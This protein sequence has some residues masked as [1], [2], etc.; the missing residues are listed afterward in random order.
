MKRSKLIKVM[1]ITAGQFLL[2]TISVSFAAWV[3]NVREERNE[4]QLAKVLLSQMLNELRGDEEQLAGEIPNLEKRISAAI[5]ML[6]ILTTS[7][8][9]DSMKQLIA[10]LNYWSNF[11]YNKATYE[12]LKSIGLNVIENDSLRQEIVMHYEYRANS[13]ISLAH[14]SYDQLFQNYVPVL[15]EHFKDFT[16]AGGATP[17]NLEP[18]RQ[19]NDVIVF[20]GIW[21]DLMKYQL[22]VQMYT[23]DDTN[24]L[25]SKIQKEISP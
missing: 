19:S 23:R 20:F 13:A 18:L 21:K 4:R 17:I 8:P 12:T 24:L 10:D 1:A 14:V 25:I 6:A 16:M 15:R 5:K 3:E 11:P 9:S 2:I 7:H 22:E